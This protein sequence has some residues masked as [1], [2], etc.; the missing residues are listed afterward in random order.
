MSPSH[1]GSRGAGKVAQPWGCFSAPLAFVIPSLFCALRSL[2]KLAP[3][4]GWHSLLCCVASG[5]QTLPLLP[6]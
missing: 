5:L 4:T 6:L 1:W 2:Q 3:R